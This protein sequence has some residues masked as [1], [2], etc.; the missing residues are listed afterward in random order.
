[1][2]HGLGRVGKPKTDEDIILQNSRVINKKSGQCN[3]LK[4]ETGFFRLPRTLGPKKRPRGPT[5]LGFRVSGLELPSFRDFLAF[6][7]RATGALRRIGVWGLGFRAKGFRH[8]LE[9]T[10]K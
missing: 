6:V 8:C 7:Q 10:Y 9:A 1:M 4:G 2:K 5:G 3:I